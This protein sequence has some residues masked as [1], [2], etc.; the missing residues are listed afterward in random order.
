MQ[1]AIQLARRGYSFTRSNPQVGAVIVHGEKII[2]EGW[3]REYGKAHAEINALRD[4]DESLQ[5]LLPQAT[6]YVTLE[7]CSI[8]GKTPSCART[9]VEQNIGAVVVG[10]IDPNPKVKGGGID[11]L[12]S[13]GIPVSVGL[14]E[15]ECQVLLQ[16]FSIQQKKERPFVHI[17]WAQS[18]DGFIARTNEATAISHRYLKFTTH[19]IRGRAQAILVGTDTLLVDNPGLDN[20]YDPGGQPTKII[21]DRKG[22]IRSPNLKVF[23]SLGTTLGMGDEGHPLKN[24][25]DDF[26][27]IAPDSSLEEILQI[28]HLRGIGYLMVEGGRSILKSFIDQELWDAATIIQSPRK[29]KQGVKAPLLSGQME[30]VYSLAGN[31]VNEIVPKK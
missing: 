29:L 6:L 18:Y 26:V 10:M 22:R 25:F 3:H 27:Q 7:P 16:P 31:T 17:K 30:K 13:A 19:K 20:R 11:L 2:G 24:H 9:L 12:K 21:L 28:I 15:K 5:S 23:S 1:R 14:L 8:I 4:V